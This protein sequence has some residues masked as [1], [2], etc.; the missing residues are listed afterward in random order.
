MLPYSAAGLRRSANGEFQPKVAATTVLLALAITLFETTQ[1]LLRAQQ[2]VTT[3]VRGTIARAILVTVFGI[4]CTFVLN[5]GSWLLVSS[6]LAFLAAALTMWRSAWGFSFPQFDGKRLWDI[7]KSGLPL[8]LSLLLVAISGMA[9]RFLIANLSGMAAAG[10]YSASIDLVRQSLIIPP[11]SIATAFVPIAVRLHATQNMQEVRFHL[12]KC[13]EILLAITLPSCIGFAIVSPQIS[14]VVLGPYFR[15]TAHEIMPIL[16]ISMI[17]QVLTAQYVHTSFLLSK[18]NAFYLINTGSSMLFNLI[19]AYF[20][21]LKFGIMGA[22]WARLASDIFAFLNALFLSRIA[23]KMPFP[24]AAIARIGMAVACMGLVVKVVKTKVFIDYGP[25][26]LS[27]S[28]LAGVCAY[29]V[30]CWVFDI[31]GIRASAIKFVQRWNPA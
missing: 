31:A 10:Q 23:F 28:V 7:V 21:I 5:A 4:S 2:K 12:A 30:A 19:V 22:V 17:F 27:I 18:K 29:A 14:D 6:A 11:I 8:T 16:S 24:A 9:D 1:E 13:L 15:Q 20:L 3:L 26:A 25:I